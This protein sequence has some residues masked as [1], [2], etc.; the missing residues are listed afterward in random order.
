MMDIG[1]S[2]LVRRG[3]ESQ[4]DDL[5][6]G[7][8]RLNFGQD[9]LLRKIRFC[10]QTHTAKPLHT[11]KDLNPPFQRFDAIVFEFTS[12]HVGSVLY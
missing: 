4:E 10:S 1:R 9:L 3:V 7:P 2:F 5:H 8:T 6:R 12:C 11:S